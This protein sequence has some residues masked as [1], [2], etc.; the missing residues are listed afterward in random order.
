MWKTLLALEHRTYTGSPS[1]EKI[2]SKTFTVVTAWLSEVATMLV[3]YINLTKELINPAKLSLVSSSCLYLASMVTE[4]YPIYYGDLIY[5]TEESFDVTALYTTTTLITTGLNGL[6]LC[7]SPGYLIKVIRNN[8]QRPERMHPKI[9]DSVLKLLS[10]LPES[11][12][13][14]PSKLAIAGYFYCMI[15][16]LGEDKPLRLEMFGQTYLHTQF[17]DLIATVET[18]LRK[19]VKSEVILRSVELA[20]SIADVK[21]LLRYEL[22]EPSLVS[23]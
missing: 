13:Y 2:R 15:T 4:E 23:K 19:A 1:T 14:L 10:L 9:F 8:S 7:P 20:D 3:R 18:M 6:M 5:V 17:T 11:Y 21:D 16:T 22:I 12:N